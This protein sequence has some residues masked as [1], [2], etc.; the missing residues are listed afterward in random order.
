MSSKELSEWYAYDQL[1]RIP[2][3]HWIGGSICWAIATWMGT[4]KKRWQID[5]FIPREQPERKM[6]PEEVMNKFRGMADQQRP[7]LEARKSQR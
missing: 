2:D 4:G 1:D 7:I 6:S 3:P 5:D